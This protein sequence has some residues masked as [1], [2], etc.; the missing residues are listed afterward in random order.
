MVLMMAIVSLMGLPQGAPP[1]QSG[2]QANWQ[3]VDQ[4]CGD[5]KLVAPTKKTIVIDG[6]REV[7]LYETLVEYAEVFVYRGNALDKTCCG[8]AGPVAST[9]SNRFG[10]FE[11]SGFPR[12]LYWLQVKKANFA[13]A[14]PLR[15]TD[16][17]NAKG[18]QA[19]YIGRKFILDAQPP[20]VE[21]RIY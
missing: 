15:V 16:D 2:E 10:R 11:F 4:L 8:S 18:C 7:R 21:T 5:L 9:R 1:S 3:K 20:R 19:R 13:G 14:I 12:G 17:F 6:K